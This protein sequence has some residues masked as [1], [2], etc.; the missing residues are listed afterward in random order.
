MTNFAWSRIICGMPLLN[1]PKV[2]NRAAARGWDIPT[3]ARQAGVNARTLANTTRPESPQPVS[4]PTIYKLAGA[5]A[6]PDERVPLIAAALV[7]DPDVAR[8]IRESEAPEAKPEK[9]QPKREPLAP[10]KRTSTER[11]TGPKRLSA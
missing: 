5:L 1:G 8:Q 10:P 7:A 11:T 9:E 2:R 6:A 4:L 3:L